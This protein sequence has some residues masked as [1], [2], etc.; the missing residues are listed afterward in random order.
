MNVIEMC[1]WNALRI[2]LI[3]FVSFIKIVPLYMCIKN[4]RT[5]FD[6]IW[7]IVDCDE[8]SFDKLTR[9]A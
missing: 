7:R 4:D 3:K 2:S 1:I 9:H 5:R 6:K 8:V